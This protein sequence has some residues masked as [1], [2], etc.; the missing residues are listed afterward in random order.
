MANWQMSFGQQSLEWGPDAGGSLM[1]SNNAEAIPMLRV[2]RVTPFQLPGPLSWLGMIRNTAFVGRVGG[3]YYLRGPYPQ[4]P[5]VGN[6]YQT[7]ESAALHVGRQAGLKMTSEFRDRR[8]HYGDVGRAKEDPPLLSPGCIPGLPHGNAQPVDPGKR[9]NGFN[10]SYRLPGLRNWLTDLCRWHGQRR[11]QSRSPIPCSRRG[12]PA[13]TFRN[14][15]IC[16]ISTCGSRESIPI[17]PTI[18]A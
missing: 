1:L 7:G 17:F 18:P 16:R 5:L 2:G 13:C 9:F 4:F 6:G 8:Y 12:I 10:F 14:L 3:Y 11:A 15:P